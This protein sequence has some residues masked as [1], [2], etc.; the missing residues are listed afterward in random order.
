MTRD[1]LRED[2]ARYIAHGWNDDEIASALGEPAG[3]AFGLIELLVGAIRDLM[4]E[5]VEE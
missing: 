4:T 1:S 3:G 2:I 5:K